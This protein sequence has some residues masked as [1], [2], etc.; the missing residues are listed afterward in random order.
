MSVAELSPTIHL[1]ASVASHSSR[2]H[3][4]GVASQTDYDASIPI[5]ERGSAKEQSIF[6]SYSPLNDAERLKDLQHLSDRKSV[7]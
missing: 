3:S 5:W 6:E 1:T 4:E 7:V 2:I